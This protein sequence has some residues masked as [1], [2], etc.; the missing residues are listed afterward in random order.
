MIDTPG[1]IEDPGYG[2]PGKQ[3]G[4]VLIPVKPTPLD[5]DAVREVKNLLGLAG[6]PPAYVLLN[7]IP[8]QGKKRRAGKEGN[9]TARRPQSLRCLFRPERTIFRRCDD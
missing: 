7:T 3:A 8:A 1:K 6:D 2:S 5:L 4:L 9:R